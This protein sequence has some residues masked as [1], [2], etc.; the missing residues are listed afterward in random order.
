M[1]TCLLLTLSIVFACCFAHAQKPSCQNAF[2]DSQSSVQ[3]SQAL[4]THRYHQT[5]EA[6]WSVYS[7]SLKFIQF[8]L[9]RTVFTT[10]NQLLDFQKNP[11]DSH[12]DTSNRYIALNGR[13]SRAA[14]QLWKLEKTL[15]KKELSARKELSNDMSELNQAIKN[16]MPHDPAFKMLNQLLND[17]DSDYLL[18][19]TGYKLIIEESLKA[20]REVKKK[21]EQMDLI[22]AARPHGLPPKEIKNDLIINEAAKELFFAQ[23]AYK[24]FKKLRSQ[25]PKM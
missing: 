10:Q 20:K 9:K 3:S 22:L 8:V 24:Q 7:N 12:Y 25:L 1:K 6:L 5:K 2:D 18:S 19:D 17:R 13:F 23:I 4:E 15:A 16:Y 11:D 14:E 21:K